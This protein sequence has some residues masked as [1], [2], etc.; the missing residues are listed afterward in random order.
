MTVATAPPI[1]EENCLLFKGLTWREFKAVE[2]LL[3]QPGY[4]I[5]FLDGT[6]E[7]QQMPG[8]PHETIKKRIA[9]LLE[10]YLLMAGFDFKPTGSMTL[11]NEARD[12]F[13]FVLS[14][15]SHRQSR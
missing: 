4:R 8:E 2:Q 10:L 13:R 15:Y 3:D 11:E 5:S 14:L 7:I 6:L 1:T 9:A 12:G